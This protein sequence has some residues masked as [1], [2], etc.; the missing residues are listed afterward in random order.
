M[1]IFT[2]YF[3]KEIKLKPKNIF[4]NSKRSISIS[5]SKIELRATGTCQ[6]DNVG[7][8]D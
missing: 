7:Y 5:F 6:V 3:N 2:I 4:D 8:I 1:R